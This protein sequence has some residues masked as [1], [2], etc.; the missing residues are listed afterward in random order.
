MTITTSAAIAIAPDTS[1]A[2]QD[3][4]QAHLYLNQSIDGLRGAI[5]GLSVPQWTFSPGPDCW[6]IAQITD[7]ILIVL[8]RASGPMREKLA[9]APPPPANHDRKSIDEIVMFRFPSRLS[10]FSAPPF[11]HPSER[12]GSVLEALTLLAST[13]QNLT[14]YLNS[15]PDM[16]G[17]ALE[18]LP[19]QAVTQGAYNLMDGYQWF[20]AAAAHAERHTKQILEVRAGDTFP[21]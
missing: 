4:E 8:E 15:A 5:K 7:H 20:L 11:V 19:L 12:F 13:Q 2:D 10:K 14:E 1:L 3:R 21:A 17:H 16:R 6:S 18:A 9:G